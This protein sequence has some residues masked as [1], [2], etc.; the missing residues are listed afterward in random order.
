MDITGSIL[1]ESTEPASAQN[2]SENRLNQ[3]I[4]WEMFAKPGVACIAIGRTP[5]PL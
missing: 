5:E 4:Q 2:R 1:T 3:P